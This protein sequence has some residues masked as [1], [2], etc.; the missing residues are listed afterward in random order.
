MI[1][2]VNSKP[3]RISSSRCSQSGPWSDKIFYLVQQQTI[4]LEKKNIWSLFVFDVQ[5]INRP[6]YAWEGCCT[7][8]T[9]VDIDILTTLNLPAEKIHKNKTLTLRDKPQNFFVENCCKKCL[10]ALDHEPSLR[11]E[12]IKQCIVRSVLLSNPA[13]DG[14]RLQE[15]S[16]QKLA[17]LGYRL[18]SDSEAA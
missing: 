13:A 2:Q 17:N 12:S 5:S 4:Q 10:W 6:L 1:P 9:I 15:E 18:L 14:E 3:P 8:L 11:K 7:Q 16:Y